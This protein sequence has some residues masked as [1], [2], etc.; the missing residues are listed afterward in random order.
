MAGQCARLLGV[1]ARLEDLDG[2]AILLDVARQLLEDLDGLVDEHQDPAD[3]GRQV[4]AVVR[5]VVGCYEAQA[6]EVES[7][8]RMRSRMRAAG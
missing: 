4:R 2:R 6:R 5:D 1:C 3:G 7:A 8:L